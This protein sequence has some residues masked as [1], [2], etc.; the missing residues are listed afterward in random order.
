MVSS[1]ISTAAPRLQN[2]NYL[3]TRSGHRLSRANLFRDR[4]YFP[5]LKLPPE[6]RNMIYGFVLG[7]RY[8]EW[9]FN[10][11]NL[12]PFELNRLSRDGHLKYRTPYEALITEDCEVV[13]PHM[14]DA[15]DWTCKEFTTYTTAWRWNM[16]AS[17]MIKD[18]LGLLAVNKH[19]RAEVVPML[20]GQSCLNL[21]EEFAVIPFL[22]D[23]T[24]MARQSIR[25]IRL[26]MTVLDDGHHLERQDRWIRNF[27]YLA[28]NM[29]NLDCLNVCFIDFDGILIQPDALGDPSV[30]FLPALAKIKGLQ[31]LHVVV[32][33]AFCETVDLDSDDEVD[34]ATAI[35]LHNPKKWMREYLEPKMQLRTTQKE[36]VAAFWDTCE[37]GVEWTS[38]AYPATELQL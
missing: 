4:P 33:F 34:L 19:I 8:R 9:I 6:I 22:E 21:S 35:E 27:E 13:C 15:G 36:K 25:E 14:I 7:K 1:S 38:Y 5:F 28:A 12:Y 32:D 29:T 10:I 3:V 37:T 23:R 2:G 24:S 30:Q 16:R 17:A 11:V 20:Y 18:S 31:R 26:C